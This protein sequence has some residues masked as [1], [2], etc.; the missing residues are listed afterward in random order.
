[1][2]YRSTGGYRCGRQTDRGTEGEGGK[3]P[4]ESPAVAT[5][6]AGQKAILL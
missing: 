5:I 3:E 4:P 1:M 6:Q 2:I